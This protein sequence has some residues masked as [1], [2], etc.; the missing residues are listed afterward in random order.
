MF[1]ITNKCKGCRLNQNTL[2]HKGNPGL[3]LSIHLYKL[4]TNR[5]P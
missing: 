5:V 2:H 1:E 3:K 4:K